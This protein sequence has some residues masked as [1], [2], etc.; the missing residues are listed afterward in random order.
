MERFFSLLRNNEFTVRY[1]VKYNPEW[2]NEETLNHI[3]KL[4]CSF[5]QLT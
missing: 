3:I 1:N 4:D 5:R 2:T